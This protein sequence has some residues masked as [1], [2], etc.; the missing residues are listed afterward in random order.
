MLALAVCGSAASIFTTVG[1]R[2]DGTPSRL[3]QPQ[4]ECFA[5]VMNNTINL[6]D[7]CTGKTWLLARSI[8]FQRID[9]GEFFRARV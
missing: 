2:F 9:A 7:K 5:V 3:R 1:T 6:I 8:K 4:L